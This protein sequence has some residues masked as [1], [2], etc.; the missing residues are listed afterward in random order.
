M[1]PFLMVDKVHSM[2]SEIYHLQLANLSS[3]FQ[4]APIIILGN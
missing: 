3:D 4:N 2:D 1:L